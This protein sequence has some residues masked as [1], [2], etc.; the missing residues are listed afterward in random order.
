MQTVSTPGV[1]SI[2]PSIWA[3]PMPMTAQKAIPETT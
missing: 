3:T 2:S 1:V